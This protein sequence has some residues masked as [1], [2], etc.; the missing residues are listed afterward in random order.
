M[1]STGVGIGISN[2]NGRLYINT[3]AGNGV[4]SYGLRIASGGGTNSLNFFLWS[5]SGT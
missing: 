3:N 4:N 2:P 5:W 1:N